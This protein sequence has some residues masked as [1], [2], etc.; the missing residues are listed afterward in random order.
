MNSKSRKDTIDRNLIAPCGMNCGIC[1]RH[2]AYSNNL[3]ERRGK[4]IHCSGCLP[5][6][7][8]CAF[9]KKYC[10]LLTEE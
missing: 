6:N 4:I 3:E 5:R 10:E 7:R 1:S 9:I 8:Q 2:L